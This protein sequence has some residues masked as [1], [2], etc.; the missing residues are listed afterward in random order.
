MEV[1]L[2][3]FP[4]D[5]PVR[6][7][8]SGAFEP[9]DETDFLMPERRLREKEEE[10]ARRQDAERENEEV[11]RRL[12]ALKGDAMSADVGPAMMSPQGPEAT[13]G[14]QAPAVG[15]VQVED[16]S[17]DDEEEEEEEEEGEGEGEA[18]Y[19]GDVV[20]M[21]P[22]AAAPVAVEQQQEEIYEEAAYPGGGEDYP[23]DM[24]YPRGDSE[25]YPED[26]A[27]PGGDED[28]PEDMAYPGGDDYPADA[29][30][31]DDEA[32]PPETDATA[33]PAK[34][35]LAKFTGKKSVKKLKPVR[36]KTV[37]ST[38]KKVT[39]KKE[40][41]VEASKVEDFLAGV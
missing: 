34:K 41:D 19:A 14:P 7:G 1:W 4:L 16:V 2:N 26:M 38:K 10:E 18:A 40:V 29:A 13:Q 8:E 36:R 9:R 27:Y 37:A 33:P 3:F 5:L 30:Y 12:A 11:E 35:A 6:N 17:D 20:E 22:S 32:Y 21:F 39:T 28:Y 15:G 31:P 23:E 24:A 25:D